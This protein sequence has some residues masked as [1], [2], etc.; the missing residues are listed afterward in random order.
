MYIEDCWSD[1]VFLQ[2]FFSRMTRHI[3][4]FCFRLAPSSVLPKL[5]KKRIG[6]G[7][8]N[9]SSSLLPSPHPP[10][11]TRPSPHW[12][13]LR[14]PPMIPPPPPA[15]PLSSQSL[16]SI[17]TSSSPPSKLPYR[18]PSL[19][20]LKAEPAASSKKKK[21]KKRRRKKKHKTFKVAAVGAAGDFCVEQ[22]ELMEVEEEDSI[23]DEEQ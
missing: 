3:L 15:P 20:R 17:P 10:A 1:G 12:Q 2:L 7:T 22:G 13:S 14:L 23:V 9:S 18:V 4:T 21:I 5:R 19:L 6:A 8:T 16:P 11:S